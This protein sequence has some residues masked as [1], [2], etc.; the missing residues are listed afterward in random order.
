M[1]LKVPFSFENAPADWQTAGREKYNQHI[2]QAVLKECTLLV[3]CGS[4]DAVVDSFGWGYVQLV[5]SGQHQQQQQDGQ[6]PAA[7][8]AAAGS[9]AGPGGSV[10]LPALLLEYAEHGTAGHQVRNCPPGT[11]LSPSTTKAYI[12]RVTKA[13]LYLHRNQDACHR[14]IKASNCLLFSMPSDQQPAAAGS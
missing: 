8:A 13:L 9:S 1:A 11:G 5:S 4:C 14:D 7:A 10:K 3:K 2:H 6:Q 12:K